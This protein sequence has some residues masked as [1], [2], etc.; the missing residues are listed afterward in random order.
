MTNVLDLEIRRLEEIID[1]ELRELHASHRTLKRELAENAQRMKE[2]DAQHNRLSGPRP[3][4]DQCPECWYLH[5]QSVKTQAQPHED[6][7]NFDLM[8]CP[9]CGRR[10]DK[11]V[12]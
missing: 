6:P 10:Y 2:V 3:A 1:L 8:V 11:P 5:G 4:E 12:D 9:A 7:A